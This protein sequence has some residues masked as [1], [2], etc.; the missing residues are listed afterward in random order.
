MVHIYYIFCAVRGVCVAAA[1]M[2]SSDPLI[3]TSEKGKK[4]NPTRV[5]TGCSYGGQQCA[6]H[7]SCQGPEGC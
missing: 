3:Y 2:I 7:Q 4:K 5:G 1:Q 6:F